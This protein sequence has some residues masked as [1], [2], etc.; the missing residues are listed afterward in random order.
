MVY[1]QAST[2]VLGIALN[3]KLNKKETLMEVAN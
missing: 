2:T 3:G 1:P